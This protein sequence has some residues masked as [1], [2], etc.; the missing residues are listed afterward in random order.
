L[1]LSVCVSSE[2]LKGFLVTEVC[3]IHSSLQVKAGKADRSGAAY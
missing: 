3:C 1:Y 2:L